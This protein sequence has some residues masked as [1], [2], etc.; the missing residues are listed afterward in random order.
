MM[1]SLTQGYTIGCK[2]GIGGIKEAYVIRHSDVD[3]V[4][5][6]DGVVTQLVLSAPLWLY[7]LQKNTCT[8]SDK[9]ERQNTGAKVWNVSINFILNTLR[10]EVRQEVQRLIKKNLLILVRDR[11]GVLW[12]LGRENGMKHTNGTSSPGQAATDR[13]GMELN[14]EGQERE[15]VIEVLDI[16]LPEDTEY[17]ILMEDGSYILQEGGDK[18]LVE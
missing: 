12:M 17:Y 13:Y 6:E 15:P 8:F 2:G 4:T 10:T 16:A 1:C 3:S 9:V 14:F 18:I 11:N 7:E 5:V